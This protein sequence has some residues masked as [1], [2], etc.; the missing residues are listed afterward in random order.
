MDGKSRIFNFA[1]EVTYIE[2]QEV[3]VE[4]GGVFNNGPHKLEGETDDEGTSG[5]EPSARTVRTFGFIIRSR[6]SPKDIEAK[7][8]SLRLKC[9]NGNS[10]SLVRMLYE[11]NDDGFIDI[12]DV[13]ATELYK[14]LERVFGLTGVKQRAF[15]ESYR[16]MR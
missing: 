1:K 8:E 12:S 14:E 16:L 9:H 13:S 4:A 10:R 2:H 3:T 7:M 5:E 11:L 6:H 15:I